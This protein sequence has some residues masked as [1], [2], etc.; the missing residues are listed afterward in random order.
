MPGNPVG[1]MRNT[2][3]LTRNEHGKK[4]ALS[5][6]EHLIKPAFDVSEFLVLS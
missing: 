1:N 2:S 3:T 4:L 6:I 5:V